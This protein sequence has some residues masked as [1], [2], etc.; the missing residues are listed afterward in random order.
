MYT[1]NL[2][3]PQASEGKDAYVVYIRRSYAVL[4]FELIVLTLRAGLANFKT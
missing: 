2:T 3:H 1:H 4:C